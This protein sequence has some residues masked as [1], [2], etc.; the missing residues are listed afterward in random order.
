MF[1]NEKILE[2]ETLGPLTRLEPGAS[3]DHTERWTLHRGVSIAKW[4]DP[5]LDGVLLSK[6]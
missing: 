2:L 6:I 4:S 1:T 5:E 3:M